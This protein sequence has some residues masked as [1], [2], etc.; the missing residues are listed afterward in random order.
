[1]DLS[2]QEKNKKIVN[3][4]YGLQVTIILIIQENSGVFLKT[5]CSY[6]L[7]IYS[8][9]EFDIESTW[10]TAP[11]GAHVATHPGTD[12]PIVV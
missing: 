8:D 11:Q 2:F 9:P 1:M 6:N 12:T 10:E 5:P 3:S 4:L 7:D